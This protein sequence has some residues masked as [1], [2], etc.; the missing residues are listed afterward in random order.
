MCEFYT[1]SYEDKKWVNYSL[2]GLDDVPAMPGVWFVLGKMP[3][4]DEFIYLDVAETSDIRNEIS[5]DID[6]SKMDLNELEKKYGTRYHATNKFRE[7]MFDCNYDQFR[8]FLWS[9]TKTHYPNLRFIIINKEIDDKD[10][11]RDLERYIAYKYNAIFW[12]D[13]RPYVYMD[14]ERKKQIITDNTNNFEKENPNYKSL[15]LA[16]KSLIK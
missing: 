11:R 2:K 1:I 3:G 16:I 10:T 6:F 4:V 15:D 14:S 12:R 5:E 9:F 8:K 13:S 7:P